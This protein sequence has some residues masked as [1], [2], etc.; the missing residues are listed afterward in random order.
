MAV[1]TEAA[2]A[3][4]PDDRTIRSYAEEL[5]LT[6]RGRQVLILVFVV[7]AWSNT[8]ALLYG[9]RYESVELPLSMTTQAVSHVMLLGMGV[10]LSM[11]VLYV[12]DIYENDIRT[13]T[14][15]D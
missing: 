3:E 13:E 5:L 2:E 4:H 14:T 7:L 9:V 1:E 10:L 15:D 6:A 12:L 8:R 11:S